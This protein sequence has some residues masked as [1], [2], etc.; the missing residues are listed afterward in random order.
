MRGSDSRADLFVG[1]RATNCIYMWRADGV[2]VQCRQPS[3]ASL[4][5]K[6]GEVRTRRSDPWT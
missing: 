5:T 4:H 2:I 1:G 6:Q 3:T